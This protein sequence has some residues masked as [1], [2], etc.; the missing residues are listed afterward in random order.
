MICRVPVH[1]W[2]ITIHSKKYSHTWRFCFGAS[3]FVLIYAASKHNV[4]CSKLIRETRNR[5]TENFCP[6]TGDF[7]AHFVA[8]NI[9]S[10]KC[11]FFKLN[12]TGVTLTSA[13]FSKYFLTNRLFDLLKI[14]NSRLYQTNR[15]K[16]SDRA[17]SKSSVAN[18]S[19][20]PL[21]DPFPWLHMT[22][23]T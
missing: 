9:C 3:S 16:L 4:T 8:K 1:S 12:K 11:Y 18:E 17:D 19:K 14:K 13:H 21:F 10:V 6:I 5:L 20:V 15:Y 2:P 23:I 22:M 7:M